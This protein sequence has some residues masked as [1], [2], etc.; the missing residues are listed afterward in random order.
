MA[1]LVA[2]LA[3]TPVVLV[4]PAVV[5]MVVVAFAWLNNTT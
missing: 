4:V 2:F 3:I 1:M 5:V